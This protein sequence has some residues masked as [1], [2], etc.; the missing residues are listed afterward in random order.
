[1]KV[2]KLTDAKNG[3]NT[4]IDITR[5]VAIHIDENASYPIYKAEEVV[6]YK[7]RFLRKKI[8][9]VS[10]IDVCDGFNAD[11]VVVLGTGSEFVVKEAPE[12][13]SA[14]V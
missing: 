8:K 7:R 6:S 3:S 14:K 10:Y 4:Y 1:M 9:V 12:E 11:T 13:V 2:V 5:I